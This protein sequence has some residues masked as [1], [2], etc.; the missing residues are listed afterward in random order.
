MARN[1]DLRQQDVNA[2]NYSCRRHVCLAEWWA[3]SLFFLYERWMA[4]FFFVS[5]RGQSSG[6]VY[7]GAAT[8]KGVPSFFGKI[9]NSYCSS[10]S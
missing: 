3:P 7:L 8:L 4:F 10:G 1:R 5:N 9:R 2:R 6:V